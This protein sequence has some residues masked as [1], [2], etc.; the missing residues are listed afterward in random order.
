MDDEEHTVI[1]HVL[2]EGW[3]LVSFGRVGFHVAQSRSQ[4]SYTKSCQMLLNSTTSDLILINCKMRCQRIN[5]ALGG[6]FL[7]IEGRI[8]GWSMQMV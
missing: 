6:P 4:D 2:Q 3:P 1:L 8:R 7:M 5:V